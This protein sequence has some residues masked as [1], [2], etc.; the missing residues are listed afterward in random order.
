VARASACANSCLSPIGM[1]V[2]AAHKA[3]QRKAD[4]AP[5][6]AV[7]LVDRGYTGALHQSLPGPG[8]SGNQTALRRLAHAGVGKPTTTAAAVSRKCSC[9]DELVSRSPVDR[10]SPQLIPPIVRDVNRSSGQPLD[11]PLRDR[12]ETAFGWDF[13][14][15]RVQTDGRA[16]QAAGSVNAFAYTSGNHLVFAEGRYQLG[17]GCGQRLLATNCRTWYSRNRVPPGRESAS[18]EKPTNERRTAGRTP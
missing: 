8:H 13:R 11:A 6:P 7:R 2:I 14:N 10:A 15:V 1:E 16:A 17:S 12:F 5:S 4:V 3:V 18:P 9:E